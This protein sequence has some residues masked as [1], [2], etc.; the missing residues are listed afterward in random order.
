MVELA[1]RAEE[2]FTHE[3]VPISMVVVLVTYNPRQ[4]AER[5]QDLSAA[6]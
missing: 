1:D 2:S 5:A 4:G 3:Y 6:S